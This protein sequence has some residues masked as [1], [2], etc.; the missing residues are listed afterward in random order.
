MYLDLLRVIMQRSR[1]NI[2]HF[3]S[4]ADSKGIKTIHL[5]RVVG[6]GA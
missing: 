4:M 5:H 1:P 3:L 6:A 2:D